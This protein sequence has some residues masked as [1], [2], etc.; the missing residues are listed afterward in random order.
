MNDAYKLPYPIYKAY[1]ETQQAHGSGMAILTAAGIRVIVEMV[2]KDKAIADEGLK[3]KIN[4]LASAGVLTQGEAGVL[5]GVR[6]LG[7]EAMHQAANHSE[8]VLH[9]AMDVVEHLLMTAYLIQDRSNLL[10]KEQPRT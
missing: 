2:C 7:N 3:N 1:R 9:A 5:H 8:D 10:P 6:V 4:G